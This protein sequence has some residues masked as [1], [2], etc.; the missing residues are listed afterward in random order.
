MKTLVLT[1]SRLASL[2]AAQAQSTL[3]WGNRIPGVL[4]APT[5]GV[6]PGNP[7]ASRSRNTPSG[8][9]AGIQTYNGPLLTGAGFSAQL[10]FGPAG[11][12]ENSLVPLAAPHATFGSGGSEARPRCES[13]ATP[14]ALMPP[15]LVFQHCQTGRGRAIRP[16]SCRP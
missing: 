3:D 1:L 8:F 5:Y 2:I 11:T 10:Y 13:R 9:L 6:D 12:P 7:T 15:F 4:L 14:R 16:G